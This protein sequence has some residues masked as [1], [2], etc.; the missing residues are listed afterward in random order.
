MKA[1]TSTMSPTLS[2]PGDDVR[3]GDD[4]DRGDADRD[5]RGL[6]GVE[7]RQRLLRLHRSPLVGGQRPVESPALVALVG[8]RLDHLVV[9]QPVDRGAA[10]LVVALVH[11][12]PEARAPV[13]G[14][15]GEQGVGDHRDE[16]D[17]RERD[18][19]APQED[20]DHQD[21]L[22]QDRRHAEQRGLQEEG[23]RLDAALDGTAQLAGAALQVVAERELEQVVVDPQRH[24]PA[25]ALADLGEHGVLQLAEQGGTEAGGT[26]G[27]EDGERDRGEPGPA[28]LVDHGLEEERDGDVDQLRADQQARRQDDA[29]AQLE[30]VAGP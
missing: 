6:P 14:D 21:E 20:A 27:D 2:V 17:P 15:D 16:G 18:G 19:V 23:D 26:V 1:L 3:G 8:E 11:L 5:D 22:D 29:D 24:A 13:G 10:E 7:V 30:R 28:D 12:A 25:G 4:H 9:D